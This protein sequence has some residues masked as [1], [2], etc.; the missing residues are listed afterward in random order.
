M[1]SVHYFSC[2]LQLLVIQLTEYVA[3]DSEYMRER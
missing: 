3:L 1:I 2:R